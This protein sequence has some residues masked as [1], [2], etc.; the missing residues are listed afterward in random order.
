MAMAE[1]SEGN[2]FGERT[3]STPDDIHLFASRRELV[4]ANSYRITIN[5][6][7]SQYSSVDRGLVVEFSLSRVGWGGSPCNRSRRSSYGDGCTVPLA[8]TLALSCERDS[9]SITALSSCILVLIRQ[10][11]VSPL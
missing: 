8:T 4:T 2:D 1:S 10:C 5:R 7:N 3:P 6:Q 9:T 11:H